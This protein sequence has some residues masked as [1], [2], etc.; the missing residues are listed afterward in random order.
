MKRLGFIRGLIFIALLGAGV[1][2]S[3]AATFTFDAG[4]GT[5]AYLTQTTAQW[6][7][8]GY[9][10][11]FLVTGGGTAS[12]LG[13]YDGIL[14][15]SG[16]SGTRW[17]VTNGEPPYNPITI[18][19]SITGKIF[20]FASFDIYDE[21]TQGGATYSISTSKGGTDS[22]PVTP[23]DAHD[24]HA[25]SGAN[26]SGISSFTLT[27]NTGSP[28]VAAVS[29]DDLILNN[30]ADPSATIT[31]ADGSGFTPGVTPG[32]ANQA[33]GRFQ[34]TGD[35]SG[36]A[37]TAGSIKL[38]GTRTGLSNL[39]LWSSS[40]A[41]FDS[42]TDTQLGSTVGGD[43][44]DGNS[45]SFSSFSSAISASGTYYF[46]TGDVAAGAIGTVQGVIVQNSSLTIS[47]GT[48]SG[49]IADAP[50]SS[51][52]V[53]LPVSLVSF[54]A[55]AEGRSVILEWMTESETDNLGFVLERSAA[56]DWQTIATYRTHDE[57]KGQGNT[58]SRTEYSFTDQTVESGKSYSY[59]LSDVSTEGKVTVYA[60][61]TVTTDQLPGTT[62][63]EKAY[64]NPFNPQTYIAYKLAEDVDV[65]ISV[66]DLLGRQVKILFNGNQMAGSYH[67]YWNGT[68][69]SGVKAPSGGYVIRMQTENTFQVQKVLL[70]K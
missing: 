20:D 59:R 11:S 54:S 26:F 39:K 50:L 47:S 4:N 18:T 42:G 70:M 22:G 8:A 28:S 16:Y 60:S 33:L 56:T 10:I 5:D 46:L 43:P 38:N 23:S 30:I 57:L 32:S 69:E 13:S 48:L 3:G 15:S 67:V 66:F 29:I 45:A 34:L 24:T 2:Q 52:D 6:T 1:F 17:T 12:P 58:S 63:M 68:N 64:P 27:F 36:A 21:A 9:T 14:G 44:G 61:L 19:V 41:T 7:E 55:R 37:M 62:E 25:Y 31:F 53:S 49:T 40:D 65:T 35:I 51:R